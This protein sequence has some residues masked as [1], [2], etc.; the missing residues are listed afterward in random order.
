MNRFAL[1]VIFILTLTSAA[2]SQSDAALDKQVRLS[3]EELRSFIA[4]PNDAN[5]P[6]DIDKNLA[7]TET[8]FQSLAGL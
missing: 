7:D 1:F 6:A 3:L 5:N 8:L 4:L 2:F